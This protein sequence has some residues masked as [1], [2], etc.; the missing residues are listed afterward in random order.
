M[1]AITHLGQLPGLAPNGGNGSEPTTLTFKARTLSPCGTKPTR[2]VSGKTWVC[3]GGA[4]KLRTLR[5]HEMYGW[6]PPV[7]TAMNPVAKCYNK[8]LAQLTDD[9]KCIGAGLPKPPDYVGMPVTPSNGPPPN[10]EIPVE[11]PPA[12]PVPTDDF[13]VVDVDVPVA[14]EP[15]PFYKK[16]VFWGVVAAVVVGGGTYYYIRRRG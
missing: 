3:S 1:L 7:T 2:I 14:A 10:G 5:P 13:V 16:P 4:W 9:A 6:G 8:Q 11:T 12:P 15:E